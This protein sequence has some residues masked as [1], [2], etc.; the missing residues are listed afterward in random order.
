MLHRIRLHLQKT[1]YP[2]KVEKKGALFK[3]RSPQGI[4]LTKAVMFHRGHRSFSEKVES[5][6]RELTT[7]MMHAFIIGSGRSGGNIFGPIMG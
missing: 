7:M 3:N 6:Y 2:P 5:R 1:T 4:E